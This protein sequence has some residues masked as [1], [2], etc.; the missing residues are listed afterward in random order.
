MQEALDKA[1]MTLN[2]NTIPNDPASAFI[3]SGIRL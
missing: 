1:G 3:P 2:K